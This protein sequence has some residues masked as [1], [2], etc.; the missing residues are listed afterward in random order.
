MINT[1]LERG[2]AKIMFL[3]ILYIYKMWLIPKCMVGGCKKLL[4]VCEE[5]VESIK[6][7]HT[8]FFANKSYQVRDNY[9]KKLHVYQFC[10]HA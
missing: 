3:V 7:N 2:K 5:P 6:F 1:K 10:T 9:M 8:I 4:H